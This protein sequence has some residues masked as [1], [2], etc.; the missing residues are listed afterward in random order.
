M[1]HRVV[2]G[3]QHSGRQ[4]CKCVCMYMCVRVWQVFVYA[5][6]GLP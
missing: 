1:V 4:F 3:V 2:F 5:E 6:S